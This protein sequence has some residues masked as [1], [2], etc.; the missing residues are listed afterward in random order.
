MFNKLPRA[1]II[2]ASLFL[3]PISFQPL[4]ALD[5]GNVSV[6]K[7]DKIN[8]N[9]ADLSHLS[10]IKGIGSKKAQAIINYRTEN[11]NFITLQDL[12]KV[13]G[14]GQST[15]TKISPFITL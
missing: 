4:F 5:V 11:G 14:I 15:L 13:K 9:N 1:F 8:I 7:T 12:V 10:M 3:L 6:V 2:I